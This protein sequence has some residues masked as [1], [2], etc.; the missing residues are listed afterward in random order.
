MRRRPT[1]SPKLKDETMTTTEE[2]PAKT[3]E[4]IEAM[5]Q[6]IAAYDAARENERQAARAAFL[7]P[8]TDLLAS[9]E[10][11]T[12]KAAV[13]AIG[14]TYDAEP[15]FGAHLGALRSGMANLAGA[16]IG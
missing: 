16:Q 10:F 12:V 14:Y 4:E 9:P 5:R 3:A 11:A 7:K 15:A 13:A 8:L 2:A 6:E 1:R